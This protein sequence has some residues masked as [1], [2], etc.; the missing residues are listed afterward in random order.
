MILLKIMA[1]RVQ[2]KAEADKCLGEDQ[3]GI[4]TGT[5][6]RDVIGALRVL[7]EKSLEHNQEIYICFVD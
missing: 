1:K 7:T 5:G 3:F 4:R 2:A 6:I